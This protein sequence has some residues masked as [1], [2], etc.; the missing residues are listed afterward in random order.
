MLQID[1]A[2]NYAAVSQDEVQTGVT[3][4]SVFTAV[5]WMQN[6]FKSFAVISDDLE[7]QVCSMVNVEA[8]F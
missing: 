8:H 6:K 3:S 2:E 1:L 5:A 4:R 7:R